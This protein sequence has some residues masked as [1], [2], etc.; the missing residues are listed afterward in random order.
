M[1]QIPSLPRSC[2]GNPEL[3]MWVDLFSSHVIARGGSSKTAQNITEGYEACV[4]Q[5]FGASEAIRHDREPEFMLGF[6][7]SV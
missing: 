3:L 4:F 1:N 7:L 2:E 5:K 6:V